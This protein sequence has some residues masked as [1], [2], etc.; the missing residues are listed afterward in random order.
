MATGIEELG[1][2]CMTIQDLF[3]TQKLGGPRSSTPNLS[4]SV[5]SIGSANV[6]QAPSDCTS[7]PESPPGD[8]GSEDEPLPRTP[9]PPLRSVLPPSC[10]SA[11]HSTF[12]VHRDSVDS[13]SYSVVSDVSDHLP[14]KPRS[15]STAT[16]PRI[17]NPRIVEC[18]ID[19]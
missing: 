1:L 12:L 19:K 4:G 18:H 2:P 11:L 10:G 5:P 15:S 9:S 8:R 6:A 16:R 17:P 14:F 3:M 7:S 13:D